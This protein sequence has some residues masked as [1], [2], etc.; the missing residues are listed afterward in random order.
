MQYDEIIHRIQKQIWKVQQSINLYS[1]LMPLQ[2][3]GPY[4]INMTNRKNINFTQLD[5][6]DSDFLIL[7]K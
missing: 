6:N 5:Q 1:S 7:I 3:Y 2:N 4:I